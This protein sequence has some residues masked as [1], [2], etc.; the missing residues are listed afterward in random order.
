MLKNLSP[1]IFGAFEG[2][3]NL[4]SMIQK[5]FENKNFPSSHKT[6][7]K[8]KN[9]DTESHLKFHGIGIQCF[10]FEKM[11]VKKTKFHN[12][13]TTMQINHKIKISSRSR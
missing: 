8:A 10:K 6:D 2:Y 11:Y 7:S 1:N 5:D 3:L 4:T 12:S 9:L 13:Q